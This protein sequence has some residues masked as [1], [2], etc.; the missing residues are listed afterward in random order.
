MSVRIPPSAVTTDHGSATRYDDQSVAQLLVKESP[1]C[2]PSTLLMRLVIVERLELDDAL[3]AVL[4]T[5][6]ISESSPSASVTIC[7]VLPLICVS[8]ATVF[9]PEKVRLSVPSVISHVPLTVFELRVLVK[10]LSDLNVRV[11]A[12]SVMPYFSSCVCS[13]LSILLAAVLAAALDRTLSDDSTMA[14]SL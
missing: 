1:T 8:T 4:A 14:G 11:S 5:P 7:S 12:P 3:A 9:E 13:V 10:V 6:W 2:M